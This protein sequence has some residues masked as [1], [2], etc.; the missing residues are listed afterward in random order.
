MH[1]NI[2][3]ILSENYSSLKDDFNK[4]EIFE[5]LIEKKWDINKY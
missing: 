3:T 1:E 4:F 2:I 5:Q